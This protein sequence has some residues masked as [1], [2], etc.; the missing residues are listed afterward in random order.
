MRREGKGREVKEWEG[1]KD[2]KR[3]KE[4]RVRKVSF[5]EGEGK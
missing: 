1:L 5:K 2:R 4:G 3:R